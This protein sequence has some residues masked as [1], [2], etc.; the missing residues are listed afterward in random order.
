[1]TSL[2][3]V[4]GGIFSLSGG[5]LAVVAVHHFIRRRAFIRNSVV[6]PGVV[7]ALREERDG[8]EHRAVRYPRVRFRAATGRDVTFESEMAGGHAWHVGE[9]VSVRYRRED[10][11]TA[12]VDSI[13]VLWG[14]PALFAG[15]A[16]VF[17]GAGIGLLLGLIG[18]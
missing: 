15:L 2:V 12:E 3:T 7:V 13:L 10:P 11:R 16:A 18:P 4:V 17:L 6:A 5:V 9:A 14:A 1:M 8:M